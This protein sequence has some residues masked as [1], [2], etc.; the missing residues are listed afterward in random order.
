MLKDNWLA[1]LIM[2]VVM[3]HLMLGF[4]WLIYKINKKETSKTKPIRNTNGDQLDDSK[5]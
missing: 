1:Y 5:S 2:G 4:V 3:L